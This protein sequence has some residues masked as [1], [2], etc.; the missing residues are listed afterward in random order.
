M[1]SEIRQLINQ[2]FL[3]QT[4]KGELLDLLV[5]QGDGEEFFKV[6]N[7]YLAQDIR[8][9]SA[10]HQEVMRSFD[11]SSARV[12]AAHMSEEER[13]MQRLETR[14]GTIAVDDIAGKKAAWDEYYAEIE[15]LERTYDQS[16]RKLAT[17][18]VM[19]R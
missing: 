12:D 13:A 3:S 11:E 16:L 5:E 7:E 2:S 8:E 9:K 15:Q 17:D 4:R 1:K 14:L 6:F 10:Q 18:M 19:A